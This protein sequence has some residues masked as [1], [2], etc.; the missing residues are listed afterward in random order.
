M[1][2]SEARAISSLARFESNW[3][4]ANPYEMFCDETRC[5]KRG[6]CIICNTPEEDEIISIDQE[7]RTQDD[8]DETDKIS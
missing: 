1:N 6:R 5:V 8:S 2:I 7:T 4:S 3:E